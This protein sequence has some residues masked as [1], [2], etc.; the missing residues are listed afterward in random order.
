MNRPQGRVYKVQ[1]K[2]AKQIQYKIESTTHVQID[3]RI[4]FVMS[5]S[6]STNC[7]QIIITIRYLLLQGK[8]NIFQINPTSLIIKKY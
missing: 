1:P 8:N 4:A 7:M 3:I 5:I 6:I 2:L